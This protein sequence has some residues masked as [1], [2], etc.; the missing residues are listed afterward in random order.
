MKC[1]NLE[2][3]RYLFST[4]YSLLSIHSIHSFLFI[5]SYFLLIV[6]SV[7]CSSVPKKPVEVLTNRNMAASQLDLANTTGNQGRYNDA[8]LILEDA[9]RL[10]IS[11]D[12]P[13]LLIKTAISKGNFLFSLGRRDDA[14]ESWEEARLEGEAS[15][16]KNLSAL[17]RLAILRGRL[18]LLIAGGGGK[19]A[20]VEEIK[21]LA[22][23]EI[24]G[25]VEALSEA[26]AWLVVGM[27]E[28]EL[29]RYTEAE[30]AI[31]KALKIHEN[32]L[33]LEEAAY[34][35]YLIASIRS[36]AGNYGGALESLRAA[37]G[38]D[39]RAENGFGLASNW[40][41]MGDVYVKAG[42]AASAAAAY[43][44]AAGIYRA[45][46]LDDLAAAAESKIPG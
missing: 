33:Y 46:D 22:V 23:G 10:A 39:R 9:R 14:F 30:S 27:A 35:C 21:T 34:D 2:K 29:G 28:K 8:L 15:G 45:I 3:D 37:V 32:S 26:S 44:R 42:D 25:K 38:F 4:T 43:R 20:E 11:A 5:I 41:A 19:A 24:A 13:P 16:D 36:V 12:D 31:R 40:Q 6:I 17:A 18:V 1:G 7:S